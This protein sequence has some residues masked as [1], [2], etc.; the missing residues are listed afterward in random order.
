LYQRSLNVLGQMQENFERTMRKFSSKFGTNKL[1]TNNPITIFEQEA[2]KMLD[3]SKTIA[4]NN[5]VKKA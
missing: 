5:A 3:A 2:K 4:E 1:D